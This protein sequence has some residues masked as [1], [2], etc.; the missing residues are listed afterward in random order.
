MGGNSETSWRP[1]MGEA[2]GEFKAVTLAEV[3]S[4]EYRE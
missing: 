1:R 3:I 2:M 4:G